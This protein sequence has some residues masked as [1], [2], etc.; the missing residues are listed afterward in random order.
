MPKNRHRKGSVTAVGKDFSLNAGFIFGKS[1]HNAE[2]VRQSYVLYLL[3]SSKMDLHN[4]ACW[5]G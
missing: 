2:A 3:F 1:S 4:C 5:L